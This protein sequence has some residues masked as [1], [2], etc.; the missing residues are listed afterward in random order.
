[1]GE[2]KKIPELLRQIKKAI[3]T[4]DDFPIELI[5]CQGMEFP[6]YKVR[7]EVVEKDHYIDSNGQKWVKSK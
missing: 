5:L 6:E 4:E 2:I 3:V 1:M 7:I